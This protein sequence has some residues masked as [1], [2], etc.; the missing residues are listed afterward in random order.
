M[1]KHSALKMWSFFPFFLSPSSV[2]CSASVCK[3]IT[4][5]ESLRF[6]SPTTFFFVSLSTLYPYLAAAP[7]KKCEFLVGIVLIQSKYDC[8][9]HHHV[10][11]YFFLCKIFSFSMGD[12]F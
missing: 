4:H 5:L 8:T 2:L 11:K 10:R 7:V 3:Q 6:M 1:D 9:N 12:M